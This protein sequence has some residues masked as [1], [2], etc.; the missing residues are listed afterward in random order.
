MDSTAYRKAY[1]A[2]PPPDARYVFEGFFGVSLFLQAYKEAV[3]YY[4]HVLGDPDYV[5]GD[6]TRGWKIGSSWLTLLL[7]QEGSPKNAKIALLMDSPAEA[8]RLQQAFINAG[9]SGEAPFDELM[10][11]SLRLCVVSDPFGTA[12]LIVARLSDAQ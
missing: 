2:D 10:Y 9:G 12:I 3:A 8:D 7:A 6:N 4:S 1:F 11:E 5:E